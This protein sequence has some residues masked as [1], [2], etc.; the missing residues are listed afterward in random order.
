MITIQ[1]LLDNLALFSIIFGMTFQLLQGN[2]EI[3]NFKVVIRT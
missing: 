3:P 1:N 2:L